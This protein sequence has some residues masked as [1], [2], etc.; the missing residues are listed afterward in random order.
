[1]CSYKIIQNSS[2]KQ[3]KR[4]TR[5]TF[6]CSLRVKLLSFERLMMITA[7]RTCILYN[8]W[9]IIFG[10]PAAWCNIDSTRSLQTLWVIV[11]EDFLIPCWIAASLLSWSYIKCET[12]QRSLQAYVL[13]PS[14]LGCAGEKAHRVKR[15]REL[16]IHL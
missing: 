8:I 9:R 7:S 2:T 10:T 6:A 13:F 1:M 3:W 12:S 14:L 16:L 15:S 5:R 11:R 4:M